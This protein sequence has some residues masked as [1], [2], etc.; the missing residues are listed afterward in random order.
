[1]GI[2]AN[3]A[4]LAPGGE[5][6]LISQGAPGRGHSRPWLPRIVPPGKTLVARLSRDSTSSGKPAL[7]LSCIRAAPR[8]HLGAPPSPGSLCRGVDY[9]L[10][11]LF[12]AEL[13]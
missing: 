9:T 1:M 4:A 7:T 13:P 8:H 2:P 10:P 3:Q 11:G 5:E 12:I 6:G